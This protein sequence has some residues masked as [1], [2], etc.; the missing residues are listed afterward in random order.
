M[1]FPVLIITILVAVV[2][3]IAILALIFKLA[4][5]VFKVALIAA[6]ILIILPVFF[7]INLFTDAK[8][9]I[10]TFPTS[11][12]LY[13]LE[14]NGK[15]LA[16]FAGT[17]TQHDKSLSFLDQSMLELHEVSYGKNDLNAIRGSNS[18]VIIF[19]AKAFQGIT[20]SVID[21]NEID[22]LNLLQ[23]IRSENSLE[24]VISQLLKEQDIKDTEETRKLMAKTIEQELGIATADDMRGALLAQL[25]AVSLQQD[26]YFLLAQF[27]EQNLQINPKTITFKVAD[28]FPIS[29]IK[30]L[31]SS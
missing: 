23:Q 6:M 24:L 21:G 17:I 13:I 25:L 16:G 20:S 12:N 18:R 14:E 1:A 3:A 29:I 11:R 9:L 15:L 4:R 26:K 31:I 2:L 27:K 22:P 7:G 30:K 19:N 8:D 10:E 5:K 28:A